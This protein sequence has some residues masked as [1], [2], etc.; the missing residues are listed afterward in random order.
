[1]DDTGRLR[2]AVVDSARRILFDGQPSEGRVQD[3]RLITEIDRA[4]LVMLTE[5][6]ILSADLAL[7]V[8][9][10]IAELR[11]T[12]F[13]PLLNRPMPRGVFLLY[14]DYLI[15][16][17]GSELGGV[18]QTARSRN[19]LNATL[20]KLTL[21]APLARLV[22]E[23]LRLQAV[24]VRQ[25]ERH[26]MTVMPLYTHMQAAVP[27]TYGHYLAGA[28][29]ALQRQ[30]EALAVPVRD[31][32]TCPLGAGTGDGARRPID[33]Q[34]TAA[35]LGFDAPVVNSIDAVASRDAA[36]QMLSAAAVLGLTFSRLA[37]DLLQWSTAEFGF[38]DLPDEVVGSSSAMPQKRN[39]FLLEHVEARWTSAL[40]AFVAAVSAMHGAPF[41]N[42]I[43]VGTEGVRH[44]SDG[45]QAV[46]DSALLLRLVA[47]R[48]KPNP[49][50]M[51]ERAREGM[52][53][54]LAAAEAL[55]D[56]TGMD[57]RSAH[58]TIGA[59][60]TAAGNRAFDGD[61]LH[62]TVPGWEPPARSFDPETVMARSIYGGGPGATA[63]GA[64]VA[65]L[66]E[67]WR[68]QLAS[69]AKLEAQ[70]RRASA[71]LDAA[72]GALGVTVGSAD[73]AARFAA[74]ATP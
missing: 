71:A 34:R 74:P 21:R 69:A 18:L 65:R 38:F 62:D 6:K 63:Q 8:L 56:A 73:D 15:E 23:L 27:S 58:R 50:R 48:A 61:V 60:I 67:R 31:L 9:Q 49:Q 42:A 66:R 64:A 36:L 16:R 54:A 43:G 47:G 24:L 1:M 7:R 4:H 44:V 3:L 59:L 12:R 52:T 46:A 55:G 72:I 41:S 32:Q 17:Y 28:V 22:R 26:R 11:R 20:H 39:P 30:T 53:V 5:R 25:A 13:D 51:A 33:P 10:A 45:L 19:D 70:W 68:G 37:S 29:S 57:F 14:E 2:R 35:L 40:G